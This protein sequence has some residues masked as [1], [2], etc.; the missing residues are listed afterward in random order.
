LRRGVGIANTRARLQQLYGAAHRFEMR[1]G[2]DGGLIVTVVIPFRPEAADL[3]RGP[4]PR[5]VK[6]PGIPLREPAV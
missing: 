4:E 5:E 2:P 6:K 3:L 1:N